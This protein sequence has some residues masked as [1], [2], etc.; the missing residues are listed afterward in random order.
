VAT[1]I[2]IRGAV[3]RISVGAWFE[4]YDLFMTAYISLGLIKAGLFTATSPTPFA[5]GGFASFVASGFAGMFFGTIIFSGISDRFGRK[6]AFVSSLVWY[7]ICTF[8]MAFMPTGPLIDLWRFL[9]GLG[10]GVQLVTSDAYVS[11]IVPKDERGKWVAFTQVIGYTSIPAAALFAYLL[12]PHTIWGLDGWRYVAL[13]GSLGGV[14]VWFV[15]PGL[16]DSSR[17]QSAHQQVGHT[18]PAFVLKTLFGPFYRSRTSMMLVFNIVQTIGFYGFNSWVPIFLATQG[19]EFTHSLQYA[20][21]I[22][23]INPLGPLLAMTYAERFQRKWQICVLALVVGGAGLGFAIARAPLTIILFGIIVTLANAWF[24]AT[25]HAYQAELFPTRIRGQAVG[26][27]YSWSRF[28]S[29]F[30][31]FLI[32]SVLRANGT[33]G[34]FAM[35]CTAM[36]LVTLDIGIF[37][38]ETNGKDLDELSPLQVTAA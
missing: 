15:L 12:V 6:A 2:N 24:S 19:V 34:V 3:S 10:I 11:E 26:F 8:V 5:F 7:S 16:P 4:L 23:I 27:V 14:V 1:A 36:I 9:A 30:V 29:I 17:W 35:I 20:F 18:G 38:P 13:I 31:P 22:A 33:L 28:A 25:F 21:F 32:A 37:G